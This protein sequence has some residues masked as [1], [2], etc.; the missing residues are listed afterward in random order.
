MTTIKL[1]GNSSGSGSVTL[2]AP[3]TN[4]TRTVTLPDADLDLG[5]LG[6]TAKAWVTFVGTGTVS[7]TDDG[8]VSS[9]TDGGVGRYTLAFTTALS[10][11][12][13]ATGAIGKDSSSSVADGG[14]P[15]VFMVK[16]FT[17]TPPSTTG[18]MVVSAQSN[19]ANEID[20]PLVCCTWSN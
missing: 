20:S 1:A 14:R 17:N 16:G 15:K 10:S 19:A 6:Y 9:L 18:E 4:A 5:S 3:N 12:N 7:I 11:A 2:T 8:N 13:Y